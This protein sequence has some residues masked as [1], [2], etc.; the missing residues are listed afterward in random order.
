MSKLE[1]LRAL[2]DSVKAGSCGLR[3]MKD[4]GV[5]VADMIVMRKA[6]AGSLDAAHALHRAV[7]PGWVFQLGEKDN[8]EAYAT[9]IRRYDFLQQFSSYEPDPARAW[10]LSILSALIAQEEAA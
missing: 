5:P 3:Q 8:G 6:F 2:H 7:L 4:A 9:V 10:L 1:A